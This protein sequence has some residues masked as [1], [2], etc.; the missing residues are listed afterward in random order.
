MRKT[1]FT[2]WESIS[3]RKNFIYYLIKVFEILSQP[4]TYSSTVKKYLFKK[5]HRIDGKLNV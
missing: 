2:K 1:K 3:L 5:I 4:F